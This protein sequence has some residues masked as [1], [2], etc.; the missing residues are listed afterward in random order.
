MKT[1][2]SALFI[3]IAATISA[4]NAVMT[5]DG[6]F[7]A[8]SATKTTFTDSTT[9]KTFTSSNGDVERVY[10]GAKGSYYLARIS[11]NGKYYRKYLK[12]E[13]GANYAISNGNVRELTK[14]K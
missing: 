1:I 5:S 9:T 10:V 13:A 14:T 12:V 4:Q 7:K 11:K 6:N 2:L 8:I 3:T